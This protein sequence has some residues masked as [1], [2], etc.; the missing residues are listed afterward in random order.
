MA[1]VPAARNEYVI[2]SDQANQEVRKDSTKIPTCSRM[3]LSVIRMF[4]IL[5]LFVCFDNYVHIDCISL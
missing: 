1:Y 4:P 5:F 3:F 2:Q